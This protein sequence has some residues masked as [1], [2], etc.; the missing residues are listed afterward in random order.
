MF[1]SS[2]L[3][4]TPKKV[5]FLFG[6]LQVVSGISNAIWANGNPSAP[7]L[8]EVT[9][10]TISGYVI[11]EGSEELLLGVSIYVAELQLGTVSNDYGFYSLTLPEG[12]HT[13]TISYIGFE[14]QQ[15]T[16][17]LTGNIEKT[18][19]LKPQTEQLD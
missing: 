16:I 13:L 15:V 18:F 1:L 7:P 8:Q 17:D 14:P 3:S 6:L 19:V 5:Y 2:L 9:S 12:R 10:H 11:E 4:S